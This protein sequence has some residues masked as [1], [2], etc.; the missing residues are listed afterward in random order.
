MQIQN[1][2][3]LNSYIRIVS[4]LEQHVNI[5]ELAELRDAIRD[6][7][8]SEKSSRKEKAKHHCTLISEG[9]KSQ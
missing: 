8:A 7:I 5:S 1:R 4:I 6:F 9:G 2:K 3:E